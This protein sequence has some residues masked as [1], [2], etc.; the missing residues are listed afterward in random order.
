[1][2]PAMAIDRGQ[3]AALPGSCSDRVPCGCGPTVQPACAAPGAGPRRTECRRRA[4]RHAAAA[5]SWSARCA[6][7]APAGGRPSRRCDAHVGWTDTPTDVSAR[8]RARQRPAVRRV[9]HRRQARRRV[10]HARASSTS[11]CAQQVAAGTYAGASP[12]T[13][14]ARDAKPKAGEIATRAED[15]EVRRRDRAAAGS[16]SARSRVPT[17]R[18]RRRRSRPAARA[19]RATCSRSISM[20]TAAIESFPLAGMLDGMRGPAARMDARRRPRP[21]RA[22]RR[23]AVRHQARCAEAEPGKPVDPKS[24]VTA[25]RARRRRSRWRWPQGARARAASSRP[26]GRSSSTPRPA[27]PQRLELAGEAT[28][29]PR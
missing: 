13:V 25:R 10:R 9:R 22:R 29:F 11:G 8:G 21:R 26:C 2:V 14:G 19:C 28:S 7:K 18:R 16:R 4:S 24:I 3:R 6:R 17:I 20:A 15:A 12:C 23:S 1:M 5:R 27:Q